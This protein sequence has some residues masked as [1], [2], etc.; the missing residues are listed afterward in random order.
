MILDVSTIY[1]TKM[2]DNKYHI[3]IQIACDLPL[4]V[5]ESSIVTWAELPL[6][7]EKKNAAE[8][9]I[10]LVEKKEMIQLNSTYRKQNKETN[11]LAFPSNLPREIYLQYPLL[12]DVILCPEVVQEECLA[13]NKCLEAHWA[14]LTIHGVLHLL[15]YDHIQEFDFK[16]MQELEVKLLAKLG[17]SNP[18]CI[19][20]R[21]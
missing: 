1:S 14:H 13:Q 18:Y 10:R 20:E 17:F 2:N 21:M 9:T 12:G 6:Y 5:S 4:L 11:V 19:Q 3:D 7:E 8:L 16:I 15:G